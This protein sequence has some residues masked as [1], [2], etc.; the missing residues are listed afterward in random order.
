MGNNR[1]TNT[2]TIKEHGNG[3][4]AELSVDTLTKLTSSGEDCASVSTR[5]QG[6]VLLARILSTFFRQ[7]TTRKVGM[8]RGCLEQRVFS[9]I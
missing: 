4:S 9:S 2:S 7:I 8:R 3:M 1:R 5:L 6:E